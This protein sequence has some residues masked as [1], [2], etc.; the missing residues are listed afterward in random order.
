MLCEVA[1]NARQIAPGFPV[2]VCKPPRNLLVI[3]DV[4]EVLRA[5]FPSGWGAESIQVE[6]SPSVAYPLDPQVI[7]LLTPHKQKLAGLGWETKHRIV[8][9]QQAAESQARL[10]IVFAPTTYEE[11]TGFHRRLI[12]AAEQRD[13]AVLVLKQ[14][15]AEQLMQMGTYTVTGVAAVHAVV[16]TRD[17][18]L[19]LCQRSPYMDYYPL[20]WS[21]SFEEQINPK[22][23]VFGNMALS[24]ATV[25]GFQEEFECS[26]HLN[27]DSVR[28]LS[29]FLQY[30]ILNL[31]FCSYLE[32]P[33]SFDEIKANWDSKTRNK[34]ENIAIVGVP[35]ILD[36]VMEL[37]RSHCFEE[38]SGQQGQFHPTA[39]YR[40][41]LS[42]LS[43][44]GTKTVFNALKGHGLG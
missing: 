35:F 14:Q 33:W 18:Q 21:V 3:D 2:F 11:G 28:I 37:L 32:A 12:E 7:K 27:I 17:N 5:P 19:V 43:R 15:L 1:Q 13:T 10:K 42:A 39:K 9:M 25:R 36:N 29:I 41:L 31:A 24:A 23:L 38:R 16:I 8:A 4:V 44:F 30:D 34:W 40:L 26:H 22:D 6:L 20:H